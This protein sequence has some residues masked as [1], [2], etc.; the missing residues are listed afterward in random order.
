MP[1]SDGTCHLPRIFE[2]VPC[3]LSGSN[4][5]TVSAK[6]AAQLV[7]AEGP[8]EVHE[9]EA[10]EDEEEDVE[11][12]ERV[13][14][15]VDTHFLC[16]SLEQA[17]FKTNFMNKLLDAG[18]GIMSRMSASMVPAR[19]SKQLKPIRT[20][21]TATAR[22]KAGGASG[23]SAEASRSNTRTR[24]RNVFALCPAKGLGLFLLVLG[25]WPAARA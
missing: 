2:I 18:E 8:A 4:C 15:T 3:K 16:R 21:L 11:Q 17:A 13:V 23:T 10:N 12:E 14:S 1:L 22:G 6:T 9:E 19:S 5:F 7:A 24:D 25:A 20:A